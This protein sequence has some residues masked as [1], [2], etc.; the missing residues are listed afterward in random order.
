MNQELS[1]NTT[2]SHYRIVEKLGA[3][4]LG[5]V[6]GAR[7][8]RFEHRLMIKLLREECTQADTPNP[9]ILKQRIK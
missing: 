2:L 5:E 8:R 4:G 6:Y 9:A 3:G 7:G 1:A